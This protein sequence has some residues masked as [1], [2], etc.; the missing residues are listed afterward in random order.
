MIDFSK[1]AFIFP[2]QGSQVV[3]MGKDFADAYPIAKE[4]YAEADDIMG[5]ALSKLM[6]EGPE[7]DLGDTALTQP[8]MYVNS[9]AIL[10]V[11]WQELPDAKPSFVAGHSLGEFTAL[12]AAGTLSF[13]DGVALVQKRGQLMKDAGEQQP[14]SM[15]AILGPDVELVQS[16]VADAS[17]TGIVVIA[18]DNCAGQ[19]VISGETEALTAATE[20][21]KERGAKR[22]IPLDV[23]VATHSPLMQPAKEAFADALADIT[24]HAPTIPV[25]QNVSAQAETE[26]EAI[27]ANLEAQIVSSVRW[28]ESVMAMIEDG[29]DTFVEI[30]SK[31]V[32]SGLLRR[33]DRSKTRH[34]IEDISSLQSFIEL[35]A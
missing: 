33:I 8:A 2:G 32:L 1:T 24:L 10:R 5:I 26:I 18:N 13:A 20:I 17:E 27:K 16:I 15:A 25:Y 28:R 34:N 4:T 11:L 22:V 3:G 14:G 9:V 31:T 23:S 19:V 21:A 7:D 29:A 12:T 6:F 30:G 35:N